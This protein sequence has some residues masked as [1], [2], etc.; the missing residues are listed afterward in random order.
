MARWRGRGQ[1]QPG[2]STPRAHSFPP[3]S[4]KD[5]SQAA[6]KAAAAAAAGFPS[7]VPLSKVQALEL[8]KG[9]LES[10]LFLELQTKLAK[11]RV[12]PPRKKA[13]ASLKKTRPRTSKPRS[14]ERPKPLRNELVLLETQAEENRQRSLVDDTDEKEADG[15][16]SQDVSDGTDASEGN[17]EPV[18]DVDGFRQVLART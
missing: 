11:P 1:S 9:E 16:P 8:L 18:T 5:A 10:E 13:D 6:R 7:S 3:T 14:I 2:R 17:V 4:S 12:V 15:Q